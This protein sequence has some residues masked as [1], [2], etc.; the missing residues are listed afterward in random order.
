MEVTRGYVRIHAVQQREP[1]R[2]TST[3]Q[4]PFVPSVGTSYEYLHSSP[5]NSSSFL[6]AS[7]NPDRFTRLDLPE[8]NESAH[9]HESSNIGWDSRNEKFD[10]SPISKQVETVSYYGREKKEYD[11]YQGKPESTYERHP[12]KFNTDSN[13]TYVRRNESDTFK[14]VGTFSADRTPDIVG[15]SSHSPSVQS[16]SSSPNKNISKFHANLSNWTLEN[17]EFREK[18]R[19]PFGKE[20]LNSATSLKIPAEKVDPRLCKSEGTPLPIYK[21][22]KAMFAKATLEWSK[23]N[24][25]KDQKRKEMFESRNIEVFPGK[26]LRI[27]GKDETLQAIDRDFYMPSKCF[28]CQLDNICIQDAS[29]LLCYSCKSICVLEGNEFNNESGGIGLG[30]KIEYFVQQQEAIER[31]LERKL[32]I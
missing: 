32:R 26:F 5:A 28:H 19:F 15:E 8:Q 10:G 30:V 24:V 3:C 12:L 13:D 7:M 9:H 22:K 6:S 31:E 4:H 29:F 20:E 25:P 2:D 21:Y 14:A 27:R 18:L 11:F 1:Y 23:P 17:S 16:T